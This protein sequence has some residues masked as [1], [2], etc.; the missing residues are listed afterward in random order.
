MRPLASASTVL[1][2]DPATGLGRGTLTLQAPPFQ[3]WRVE[4]VRIVG[5]GPGKANLIAPSGQYLAGTRAANDDTI[6]GL[7][8]VVLPGQAVTLDIFEATNGA[9]HSAEV[10]GT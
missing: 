3:P 8:L 7:D 6:A 10:W 2:L 1:Y 9:T 4:V 5:T